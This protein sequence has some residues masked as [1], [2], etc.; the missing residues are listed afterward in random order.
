MD[1]K[2]YDL[3]D[4][5]GVEAIVYSEEDHPENYLGP[6]QTEDGIT[7]QAFFPDAKEAKVKVNGVKKMYPMD[8][9]DEAG[10]FAVLIPGKKIPEYSIL[11]TYENG[12]VE[13]HKDPYSFAPQITEKEAKKFNAGI[14]YDIYKK[15]GAHPMNINGTDGVYFAVWAPNA[16]RVSVVG[17]FNLWDGRKLPMRRFGESGIFELFVPGLACG[18]IYKYEI[19]AK[20]G[21]TYLKADPYA[22]AAELRPNTASI[23]TD[24]SD[25]TWSDDSWME[26]RKKTSTKDKP[27][28]IYE[29][30]LGSFKK[31]EDDRI[32]YNYR[33]LAPMIADYVK[34]MGYTHIELLPIMEHPFDGSWG[35]QVTG[36]Y[37]PTSR[38]GTPQDFMYFMNYMHEQGIGVILDWV[39]A[40]FPRDTFG[41][42]S[43]DGTCLYEHY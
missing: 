43:F 32:F 18:S 42:S 31:P 24:L 6:H 1:K 2:L 9:E 16:M 38:Y 15:L 23:V 35:Y 10:Y 41:L 25:F 28:F 34:E 40:H 30:H 17:D 5:A 36:Y 7:I 29:L 12:T 27:M 14:C 39:P 13:E 33:E 19:K 22:N 8:L 21:L 11:V 37:A 20:G 26:E 4:W 3:M